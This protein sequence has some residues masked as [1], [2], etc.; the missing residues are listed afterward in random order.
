MK[1]LL[2][3]AFFLTLGSVIILDSCNKKDDNDD[4]D[5]KKKYSAP[6][7]RA[8]SAEMD[9]AVDQVNDM[10]SNNYGGG[11]NMKIAAGAAYNLPCGV[12]SVDSSTTNGNGKKIYKLN[13]GENTPCGYKYKSGLISFQ[14]TNGSSFGEAGA[15]F[16]ITF[17]NYVV[18]VLATGSYVKLNGTITVENVDGGYAWQV[19][20][21]SSL[22]I[23]H[24]IR[25][26]L[27]I[28]Y[29]DNVT[30]PRKY[31]QLRQWSSPN[32]GGWANLTLTVD[33][34]S[35]DA[36]SNKYSESGNTYNGNHPFVTQV[37]TPLVWTNCGTT[38]A[39][40]YRLIQG[41]A[42]MDVTITNPVTISPA[43]ID[44]EAGYYWN[45]NSASSTP[46]YAGDCTSNAYKIHTVFG[47]L[48]N[49][50]TYQ[51]Y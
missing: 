25:G 45:Y 41:H 14:L 47:T 1:N 20:N 32:P 51:L 30:R 34:D 10:I 31:Y 3:F 50:T 29:H 49:N 40:P 27:N 26:T 6:N 5:P 33:G 38:W 46:V 2:K 43:Y 11:S 24:R 16:T 15:E 8:A 18:E 13:Y 4:P 35:I 44:V 36:S 17:T 28:T 23:S 7:E 12:V 37:L 42:K 19:I 39:G 21:N 22:T 48:V 9:E